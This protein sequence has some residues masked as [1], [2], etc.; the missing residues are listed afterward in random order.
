[1]SYQTPRDIQNSS[2]HIDLT[3]D[4]ETDAESISGIDELS[5]SYGDV[6]QESS[7]TTTTP[8]KYPI[9]LPTPDRSDGAR[10]R[11]GFVETPM[12]DY[13]EIDEHILMKKRERDT[14]NSDA[15]KR[16]KHT[17][18]LEFNEDADEEKLYKATLPLA[19]RIGRFKN[20]KEE[21]KE[22]ET[23]YAN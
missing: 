14:P 22:D 5:F 19:D 7:G 11:M 16:P 15:T 4:D 8:P 23:E 1:M 12:I 18:E 3:A 17:D 2:R 13:D 9:I 20:Y 10:S 21:P 6:N